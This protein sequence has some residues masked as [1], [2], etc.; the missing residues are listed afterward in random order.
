[1]PARKS[2]W[3][4][5]HASCQET[6]TRQRDEIER[7]RVAMMAALDAIGLDKHLKAIERLSVALAE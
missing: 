7:L 2:R 1:M 5:Q 6:I 3:A 4:E